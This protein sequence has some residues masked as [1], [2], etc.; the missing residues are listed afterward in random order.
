VRLHGALQRDGGLVFRGVEVGGGGEASGGE[1]LD[2]VG[3]GGAEDAGGPAFEHD[4]H[5]A[6][7]AGGFVGESVADVR[8]V[9]AE[10]G[11]EAHVGLGVGASRK[12]R[13][14]RCRSTR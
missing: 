11:S 1:A 10:D 4:M 14:L 7:G 13:I 9:V 8:C 2:V 5:G 3:I 6:Q 12:T